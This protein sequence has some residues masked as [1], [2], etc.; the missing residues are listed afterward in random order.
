[1]ETSLCKISATN[2]YE[3]CS[4]F[5]KCSSIWN[6]DSAVES[7]SDSTCRGSSSIISTSETASLRSL[8]S[9]IRVLFLRRLSCGQM[10]LRQKYR[11][12]RQTPCLTRIEN[13]VT[14]HDR[15]KTSLGQTEL[16]MR[17]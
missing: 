12:F 8:R 13:V 14:I 10:I 9:D 17:T 7:G 2:K 5:D 16:I 11:D 15:V 1:M 3:I 6:E 4:I